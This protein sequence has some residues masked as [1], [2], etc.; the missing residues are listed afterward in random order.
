MVQQLLMSSTD[1]LE[2]G[3]IVVYSAFSKLQLTFE[4]V[5]YLQ[6]D[7]KDFAIVKWNKPRIRSLFKHWLNPWETKHMQLSL[8]YR[9]QSIMAREHQ[10]GRIEDAY[11][12]TITDMLDSV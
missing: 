5:Y 6:Y 12:F 10:D 9:G 3:G 1:L 11:G 8:V 2:S 7:E 4:G